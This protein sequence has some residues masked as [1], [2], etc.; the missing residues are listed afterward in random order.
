MG[1]FDDAVD[2]VTEPLEQVGEFFTGSGA[3]S[4]AMGAIES[5][6]EEAL[7]ML[8]KAFERARKFTKPF[9]KAGEKALD[10]LLEIALAGAP[11]E[12]SPLGRLLQMEA[13]ENIDRRLSSIG[14]FKSGAGVE[15][16]ARSLERIFAQDLARQEEQRMGA[17]QTLM[18]IGGQQTGIASQAGLATGLGGAE[19]LTSAA[20]AQAG[21]GLQPTFLQNLLSNIGGSAAQSLPQALPFLLAA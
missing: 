2:F 12:I 3:R 10:P 21:I 1:F 14:Q 11:T 7:R 13:Q 5:G 20:G 15:A 18:G 19:T 17:L 9:R 16:G 4:G 6:Q 8:E